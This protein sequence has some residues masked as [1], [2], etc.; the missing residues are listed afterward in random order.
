MAG[1]TCNPKQKKDSVIDSETLTDGET[2]TKTKL[3]VLRWFG[4]G[5]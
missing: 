5:G 3:A 4:H 1:S 2:A